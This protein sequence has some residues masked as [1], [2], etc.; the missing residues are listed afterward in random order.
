M[1]WNCLHALNDRNGGTIKSNR[2]KALLQISH[3][4]G[5]DGKLLPG[6]LGSQHEL[7]VTDV[8]PMILL[9]ANFFEMRD[10]LEAK[11]LVQGNT[12]HIG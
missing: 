3:M 6:F 7:P 4:L 5:V 10:L 8:Y 9:I 11:T 1:K 2:L 12:L